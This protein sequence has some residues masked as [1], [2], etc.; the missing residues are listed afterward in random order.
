MQTSVGVFVNKYSLD[1]NGRDC[2]NCETPKLH[3]SK[4]QKNYKLKKK[5]KNS[6]KNLKKSALWGFQGA[7][8]VSKQKAWT[9]SLLFV[10]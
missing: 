1:G 9:N 2:L 8:K 5:L 6:R 4:P 10:V 3:Y 7:G